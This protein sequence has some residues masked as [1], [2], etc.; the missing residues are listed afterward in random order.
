MTRNVRHN[1]PACS[2]YSLRAAV[3]TKA[4]AQCSKQLCSAVTEKNDESREHED[5]VVVVVVVFG[6]RKGTDQQEDGEFPIVAQTPGRAVNWSVRPRD[7]DV[8]ID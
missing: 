8:V 5:V 4:S 7:A 6:K 1:E 3:E 2:R